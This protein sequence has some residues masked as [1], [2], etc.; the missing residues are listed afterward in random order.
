MKKSQKSGF[1]GQ[2]FPKCVSRF[3]F[4]SFFLYFFLMV[5]GGSVMGSSFDTQELQKANDFY[6]RKEYQRA[7]AVYLNLYQK[8]PYPSAALLYNLGNAYFKQNEWG[9]ALFY[10]EKAR[11]KSPRDADLLYNLSIVK[12]RIQ[13]PVFQVSFLNSL[14][15]FVSFNEVYG[16]FVCFLLFLGLCFYAKLY[17][18]S[19]L[20]QGLYGVLGLAVFLLGVLGVKF[21]FMT[22]KTG[23]VLQESRMKSG[24]GDFLP[25]VMTLSSG[26]AYAVLQEGPSFVEIDLGSGKTGWVSRRDIGLLP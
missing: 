22:D 17:R 18:Y 12:S 3:F 23:I 6:Q 7:Q 26:S 21:F 8:R 11:L 14:T 1:L 10:Y 19:G 20:R 5:F 4:L 2:C 15:Q 13:G 9:K 25:D 24:P 16:L